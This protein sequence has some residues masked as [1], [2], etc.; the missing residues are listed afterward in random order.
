MRRTSRSG[1]KRRNYDYRY[2][3]SFFSSNV[4]SSHATSPLTWEVNLIFRVD[5]RMSVPSA[6]RVRHSTRSDYRE[7]VC[8]EMLLRWA[9]HIGD[10]NN[11]ALK[12]KCVGKIF[13]AAKWIE[14][15]APLHSSLF[16]LHLLGRCCFY[17]II[18][19]LLLVGFYVFGIGD[20]DVDGE[21]H[22]RNVDKNYYYYLWPQIGTR[23]SRDK[24]ILCLRNVCALRRS[25]FY[26]TRAQSTIKKFFM[27]PHKLGIRRYNNT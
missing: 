10:N 9:E 15:Q 5:D 22:M 13:S 17:F 24:S 19:K 6:Q 23:E 20:G 26:I 16:A 21:T 12:I 18:E 3:S 27:R 1:D 14:S 25:T 8:A 11:N 7:T 4:G 2:I